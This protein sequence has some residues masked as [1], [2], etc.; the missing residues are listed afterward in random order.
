MGKGR[1]WLGNWGNIISRELPCN[2][3]QEKETEIMKISSFYK[4]E[5]LKLCAEVN[6]GIISH[7]A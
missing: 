7:P 4:K 2:N 6:A 5:I 1:K 3:H